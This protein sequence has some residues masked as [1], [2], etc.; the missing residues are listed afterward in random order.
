MTTRSVAL[1]LALGAAPAT[2]GSIMGSAHDFTRYAW[3][4]G[5]VCVTCHHSSSAY[6]STTAPLWNHELSTR[7]YTLYRSP[8]MKAPLG[9]PGKVSR[10]CLSCHDG[11]VAIDSYAGQGGT[12]YIS[13]ANHL[14]TMLAGDHP[15]G[16]VYDS[17][18]AA[19]NG[20]LFDPGTKVVTIGSGAQTQ[21]GIVG[22]LLLNNGQVE[23][24]SCHDVH[25][26]YTVG[27]S[28]LL[29][30]DLTRSAICTA[31]HMK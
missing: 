15:I 16:F 29:K 5:Q 12:Q 6:A 22:A 14:G 26:A 10:L 17:A 21:T 3:S 30:M 4:G 13:Q 18:L 1:A 28:G 23:C 8:T 20:S 9:Q 24:T 31:C 7:T 19:A 25:N 27:K 2:A 11:T